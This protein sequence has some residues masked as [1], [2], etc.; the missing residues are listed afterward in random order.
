MTR[1]WGRSRRSSRPAKRGGVWMLA[2]GHGENVDARRLAGDLQLTKQA[3]QVEVARSCTA[4]VGHD[5]DG[6][7]PPPI[8]NAG[9]RLHGVEH[10]GIERRRLG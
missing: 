5:H 1:N 9:Q 4:P 10:R 3:V 2:E 6:V 8:T 7:D